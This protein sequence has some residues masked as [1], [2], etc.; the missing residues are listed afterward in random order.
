MN[1]PNFKEG[2]LIA[3]VLSFMGSVFFYGISW[4]V[5]SFNQIY[6]TASLLSFCY[7]T[8]LS[9]R[10]K[11]KT[12]RITALTIWMVIT[13]SSWFMSVPISLFVLIQ[14]AIIWML[15]S[16][17]FYSSL[18]SSIADLFLT[19]VSISAALWA[20]FHSG[21]LFL[22][23]WCLF[24]IQ[25]LFVFIPAALNNKPSPDL[26]LNTSNVLSN[27]NSVNDFDRAYNSAKQALGKLAD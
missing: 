8:Y 23:L 2:L 16:L 11:V 9:M 27:F 25:S 20:G 24:L 5:S 4:F 10:S 15:R 6:F 1:T 21:T 26:E 17:Y 18:F 13:L 14:L 19:A 12:G 7:L 22:A 3:F